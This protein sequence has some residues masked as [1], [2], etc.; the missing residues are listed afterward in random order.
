MRLRLLVL[1][2]VLLVAFISSVAVY[3][4]ARHFVQQQL[5]QIERAEQADRVQ[6]LD[7]MLAADLLIFGNWNLE[8]S[9]WDD[10]LEYAEGDRPFYFE[11]NFPEEN[12][13]STDAAGT[14]L[15][16][17]PDHVFVFN[18]DRL[19]GYAGYDYDEERRIMTPG[20]ALMDSA[21]EIL[22]RKKADLGTGAATGFVRLKH[23]SYEYALSTITDSDGGNVD[24][25][26]SYFL[27]LRRMGPEVIADLKRST[28]F[29]LSWLDSSTKSDATQYEDDSVVT[30]HP[31]MGVDGEPAFTVRLK[32]P[33]T[34][35]TIGRGQTNLFLFSIPVLFFLAVLAVFGAFEKL[36]I[37]RISRLHA[38]V[39]GAQSDRQLL[40]EIQPSYRD[41]IT[42]LGFDFRRLFQSL[43]GRG[44]RPEPGPGEKSDRNAA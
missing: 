26:P 38:I 43:F 17:T 29:D 40:D 32:A 2:H 11:A 33:R 25:P 20:K 31:V 5:Q 39:R 14:S 35:Q 21:K 7:R 34:S 22:S 30:D 36:A 9:K 23:M 27:S 44:I 24:N 6:I 42:D 15:D 12:L 37:S 13:G 1:R 3:V 4:Y 18:G 19:V 41:E 16:V 10:T 28:T 8:Y